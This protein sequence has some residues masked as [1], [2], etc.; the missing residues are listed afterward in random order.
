MTSVWK[1][2]QRTGKRASRF[3]FVASYQELILE[4]TQKWQPDKIVI[5]WTRR[6]RRVCSKAHSWQPG[7]KDPFRGSVVWAVPENVDITAT[8]YRDPH[9]DHFEEK[10]WT[11][12]VEGE[13]RGH[14]KLL[15]VAPIDLRKFA[16]INSAP[17]E[18]RLP[19]TPRSVKVVSAA[20]TV[21]ITCTLLREGKATDDDMQSIASLL[22][23]KPSD[24]AD[25][26]D[27]ND[28]E[29]EDKLQRQNRSS[30][31]SAPREPLRELSTLAEEDDETSLSTKKAPSLRD[32]SKP[33]LTSP[34]PVPPFYPRINKKVKSDKSSLPTAKKESVK[35][36]TDDKHSHHSNERAKRLSRRSLESEARM[37]AVPSQD[38]RLNEVWKIREVTPDNKPLLSDRAMEQ[39]E[40]APRD[41]C[42]E[43]L[44]E[45]VSE[46]SVLPEDAAIKK[47][48][49][50][51][52]VTGDD[53]EVKIPPI[54]CIPKRAKAER[55]QVV[56]KPVEIAPGP[57]QFSYKEATLGDLPQ[58]TSVSKDVTFPEK[59]LYA[60]KTP[61]KT[62]E[63]LEI[64]V[65]SAEKD[66]K[67]TTP[68]GVSA[69]AIGDVQKSPK[70]N[71]FAVAQNTCRE[72]LVTVVDRGALTQPASAGAENLQISDNLNQMPE[73]V[74]DKTYT[75]VQE[76]SYDD[77]GLGA[78]REHRLVETEGV[79]EIEGEEREGNLENQFVL[80]TTKNESKI[81]DSQEAIVH[82]GQETKAEFLEKIHEA[83]KEREVI[84]SEPE[85]I[86][87]VGEILKGMMYVKDT[88]PED[89]FCTVD[90]S[91]QDTIECDTD[92][93]KDSNTN[94]TI[95]ENLQDQERIDS[96]EF[97]K[98]VSLL[99]SETEH[100]QD[101]L[102]WVEHAQDTLGETEHMQDTVSGTEH[103]Q[104][105]LGKIKDTQD[106]L[107]E[108]KHTQD[109]LGETEH[110]QD[111]LGET[112]HTQDT[113]GE[114]EHTQDT[115]GEVEHT[116]DMLGE[117]EHTQDTLG[118]TEHTQDTVSNTE[119]M[120]DTLG[121]IKDT[122]DTLGETEHMQDTLGEME[123]MQD[124]LGETEHTQ[125]TVDETKHTQ[126]TLD[127]QLSTQQPVPLAEKTK[128]D[129][130][131]QKYNKDQ[132]QENNEKR[133][134]GAV[135]TVDIEKETWIKESTNRS[136]TRVS[137]PERVE[138]KMTQLDERLYQVTD[139]DKDLQDMTETTGD[140][141]PGSYITHCLIQCTQ[142]EISRDNQD[143]ADKA[144]DT[145]R[146]DEY[147]IAV[148]SDGI[149][150]FEKHTAEKSTIDVV[151][152]RLQE[153]EKELITKSQ[154]V[155]I[156]ESPEMA[157]NV[158]KLDPEEVGIQGDFILEENKVS[159]IEIAPEI[160]VD[161]V[162]CEQM[163]NLSE[164][165]LMSE[166]Y[167]YP[168]DNSEV[169]S[170]N[171]PNKV[172]ETHMLTNER[173]E[174]ETLKD[175]KENQP[176]LENISRSEEAVN[177]ISRKELYI[178]SCGW[179][180]EEASSARKSISQEDS[181]DIEI[182]NLPSEGEGYTE[183]KGKDNLLEK[184]LLTSSSVSTHGD[185]IGKETARKVNE[186]EET[187]RAVMIEK[188]DIVEKVLDKKKKKD[189]W[190]WASSR[191]DVE[192]ST[193]VKAEEETSGSKDV[194]DQEDV[195][196]YLLIDGSLNVEEV[197]LGT[198]KNEPADIVKQVFA[199]EKEKD[200]F[201]WTNNSQD[202][203]A[204]SERMDQKTSIWEIE[205]LEDE[206]GTSNEL[207]DQENLSTCL[208]I[209]ESLNVEEIYLGTTE[210]GKTDISEQ[211]VDQEKQEYSGLQT[212]DRLDFLA[213][214]NEVTMD[215]KDEVSTTSIWEIE[216]LEEVLGQ[217]DLNTCLLVDRNLNIEEVYLGATII[218]KTDLD[219]Q[220]LDKKNDDSCLWENTSL[221]VEAPSNKEAMDIKDKIYNKGIHTSE[222]LVEEANEL[223]E[224][225]DREDLNTC[226]LID[227]SLNVEA[228]D[229]GTTKIEKT[230]LVMQELDHEKEPCFRTDIRLVVN[231][232]NQ[233]YEGHNTGTH[234]I[235]TLEN[236]A[237]EVDDQ[238]DLKT[239]L[240]IDG[241]LKVE[242]V[243][244]EN[245]QSQDD[246][247]EET[248]FWANEE[249]HEAG[250]HDRGIE[251]NSDGQKSGQQESEEGN[252]EVR[253]GI[254]D[255]AF[256][257]ALDGTLQD[258]E[259]S[260][261]EQIKKNTIESRINTANT[262]QVIQ[263]VQGSSFKELE[264]EK[265]V[266][267]EETTK[268][269]ENIIKTAE[270]PLDMKG[271][272]GTVVEEM[273]TEGKKEEVPTSVQDTSA[274]MQHKVL[275]I[276][277]AQNKRSVEQ[278]DFKVSEQTS[279]LRSG[280]VE[281]DIK[282]LK[283]SEKVQES[284]AASEDRTFKGD[285]S[286]EAF[287]EPVSEET[288]HFR[289]E[290]VVEMSS[291]SKDFLQNHAKT[292]Q[293]YHFPQEI[294]VEG[295]KQLD[296]G[297][298]DIENVLEDN[299]E[300]SRK[301]ID[302]LDQEFHPT[303]A[304]RETYSIDNSSPG[305]EESKAH[306]LS[307]CTL[308]ISSPQTLGQQWSK[309][310]KRL[311][312][313]T[314]QVGEEAPSTDSLLRWCQEVTSGYRSVRVNNFT[315]SW[316]NGLAFCAILHHFHPESINYDILDP[317]NVKENNKKAYDGFAALG[318]PPLLSP[319]DM[320]LCAVPDKLIILTYIC[321]IQ[322]HFTRNKDPD[323]LP[324]SLKTVI[325]VEKPGAVPEIPK[326][327]NS[328]T[329]QQNAVSLEKSI[330]NSTS[331][332]H[333][334][335][336]SS[337]TD[338]FL[339]NVE[340]MKQKF[341]SIVSDE[342]TEKKPVLECQTGEEHKKKEKVTNEAQSPETSSRKQDLPIY[343]L[344]ESAPR[345][346]TEEKRTIGSQV[347]E[348]ANTEKGQNISGV[349]PPP[350]VKKRLSVNGGLLDMSLDEGESS[351]L[352][353]VA[354]PRKAGGLGHLR[355]AD[356]VKKRRSLIRSQSL[357]QDEETDLT[358]K[359]HEASSRP[360]SQIINEPCPS[361]STLSSSTVVPTPETPGKEEESMVL[362]D[363][364]QYV[365]SELEAL[366]H[367]Q[368]EIDSRA[369]IVEKDL[370][371]MMEKGN[372]K[373]AEEALIQEWFILVNR[374][375][376]LIR[377]QDELQLM[378]EEQDL[379]RRFELLSRDLRALL[380]TDECLKS[381]AQKR[382][383]KLLLEELVSLVDQR[384]GLVRDLH[385]KE[386]KAVEEDE[387]IERSLEQRRRKLSK[388]E[389]CQIS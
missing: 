149:Q 155:I 309:E 376:A 208:L 107:D 388:K 169:R 147:E 354:P 199:H 142:R 230:G 367:Q 344:V 343:S 135:T 222:R 1:R 70:A 40:S 81:S 207:P 80:Q 94:N 274:V 372:D 257:V 187:L 52:I 75:K 210:I 254:D 18:V 200:S 174:E 290:K 385:I 265:K 256:V 136:E 15:A 287:K 34:P 201:F 194:A 229:L 250:E 190:S 132:V 117:T 262:E 167:Q 244:I 289:T 228:V 21:S 196:T 191:S 28:E 300:L 82:R 25:L 110:T 355:D 47:R 183:T 58:R 26:D 197:Y 301:D 133:Q 216:R 178:Q 122:Q 23:L 304:P 298:Q 145:M 334:D 302:S 160:N 116:Q 307:E 124:T 90:A 96:S 273:S 221:T 105:A 13:S 118:E 73:N 109:T 44:E 103:L 252:I 14:K 9:S 181:L 235:K 246:E 166:K 120:Q 225:P 215:R 119:Y 138:E 373:E 36:E 33:S 306:L 291:S 53:T 104:D 389:K 146:R 186:E 360:S 100:T 374:K 345:Y 54:P 278:V 156:L 241:S 338:K 270:P 11:F 56:N 236:K 269:N 55:E 35:L 30:V 378:A 164:D 353:P 27:F 127:D 130:P 305:A 168:D 7:I 24:I 293:G 279:S 310:K 281:L 93:E 137:E 185:R 218:E 323:T 357:S 386:R 158:K 332:D 95:L 316:R 66:V 296:L 101:S 171:D 359:S 363:T 20:L 84:V 154:Y 68:S 61:D 266:N 212:N 204:S 341:S 314:G 364:S 177:L 176:L 321:Q 195:N 129:M 379:E 131:G 326:D 318:I 282:D 108:T 242:P 351:A 192:E 213:L 365:T 126:D 245:P 153:K 346:P 248:W 91:L 327:L 19:L 121:E 37:T 294:K 48:G 193:E 170:S 319:S 322:S 99:V 76:S 258:T 348:T 295:Q 280:N 144:E 325:E 371:L 16:A 320:L 162:T 315:T 57:A 313:S 65:R 128:R 285:V 62:S 368:D 88:V 151:E 148:E 220:V 209:D 231:P 45:M 179:L 251:N 6:N 111:T 189:P 308:P 42:R 41:M 134:N 342:H 87:S 233:K 226:S 324:T 361:T 12:Q 317:L 60:E 5:V 150:T 184:C 382:R 173:P 97:E 206:T 71:D 247:A 261:E 268:T 106:T 112:E 113:L 239:C 369:A 277:N 83:V 377:R 358:G 375:N 311:S 336:Q 337:T 203:K 98:E 205:K 255:S 86:L 264:A 387:L 102:G 292:L 299:N 227:G 328:T 217:E 219:E 152:S 79:E 10:E 329:K 362:K 370:R 240:S 32:T 383:E 77:R 286:R 232:L 224:V 114:T 8:L 188:T 259:K 288:Q 67:M 182:I 276:T 347:Q 31:G 123:H 271:E 303:F 339:L 139:K 249:L 38:Q 352:A 2:L 140:K 63:I 59:V 238:E 172:R 64:K 223:I 234:I 51:I 243:I 272:E 85:S 49:H 92:V 163:R 237:T 263:S 340:S 115:L 180:D 141:G 384:D 356:L 175:E 78:L 29:E 165:I 39:P 74:Q 331:E 202:L 350:R 50:T 69:K 366:E 211:A 380:C 17:R 260:L 157:V 381:E 72:G 198:T 214:T 284:T 330:I 267:E 283:K 253:D 89:T 43:S 275:E 312:Q 335:S 3:Q 143:G 333:I 22:S 4:C 46:T 349:V 159:E 297:G 161:R 125:G